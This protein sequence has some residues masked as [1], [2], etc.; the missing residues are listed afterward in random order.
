[1]AKLIT[2]TE[3]DIL[4]FQHSFSFYDLPFSEKDEELKR[5]ILVN[6][7]NA[8]KAQIRRWGPDDSVV[9]DEVFEFLVLNK[10]SCSVDEFYNKNL[11]KE[12]LG[13]DKE[14]LKKANNEN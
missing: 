7:P 10:F 6:L 11:H 14:K 5:F 2:T 4:E 3:D 9:R 12:L 13:F 1:M 8:L